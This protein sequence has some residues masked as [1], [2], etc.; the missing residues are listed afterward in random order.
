MIEMHRNTQEVARAF[1]QTLFDRTGRR[2]HIVI[3]RLHRI[4]LDANR[5][6]GEAAQGNATAETAWREFH[7]FIEAA[8]DAVFD[9]FGRG[10]Y[11]DLHG[12]GHDNQRR[13]TDG[14]RTAFAGALVQALEVY[15]ATRFLVDLDL[16]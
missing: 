7:E 13:D 4:K 2:P 1:G 6:I 5:E 15:M 10:L 9:D 16:P 3:N 8:K 14:S 11:I 12:H